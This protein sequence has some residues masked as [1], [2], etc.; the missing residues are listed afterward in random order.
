MPESMFYFVW[1]Y[2]SLDTK[3]EIFYIKK[4]IQCQGIFSAV[5][6]SSIV[7]ELVYRK[8]PS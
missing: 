1:N 7:I 5:E 3:D 4:I 6:I 2:D 8:G